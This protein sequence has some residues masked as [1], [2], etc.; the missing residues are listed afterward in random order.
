MP[1]EFFRT[2]DDCSVLGQVGI[3][4]TL[5]GI[6]VTGVIG[7]LANR[8]IEIRLREKNAEMVIQHKRVMDHLHDLKGL[9]MVLAAEFRPPEGPSPVER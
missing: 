9:A 2:L 6:I 8:N 3:V 7:L 5:A 4:L 1:S